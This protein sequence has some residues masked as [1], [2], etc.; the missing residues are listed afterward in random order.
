M[1]SRKQKGLIV[2]FLFLSLNFVQPSAAASY[3]TEAIVAGFAGGIGIVGAMITALISSNKDGKSTSSSS[4]SPTPEGT[5][6]VTGIVIDKPNIPMQLVLTNKSTEYPVTVVGIALDGNIQGVA[7]GTIPDNC[8]PIP[9]GGAATCSI[10]LTASEAAYG[11]GQATI[12]YAGGEK[13]ATAAVSVAPT[14][15]ELY[16]GPAPTAPLP[17]S[18][19]VIT[20]IILQDVTDPVTT[21][22]YYYKNAG[23]F[24]WQSPGVLWHDTF[25]STQTPPVPT[26]YVELTDSSS[27]TQCS[28][29]L[30]VNVG[31]TCAFGLKYKEKNPGDWGTIKPA[32]TN[33][34]APLLTNVLAGGALSVAPNNDISDY[35]LGYR[36]IKL[37][38]TYA[39]PIT[40]SYIKA[41]DGPPAYHPGGSVPAIVKS[42]LT[43]S[44]PTYGGY[45]H[46]KYCDPDAT[47]CDGYITTCLEPGPVSKQLAAGRTCLVWFKALSSKSGVA[48]PLKTFPITEG[49]I[50]VEA[51]G[52]KPNGEDLDTYER[53]SVFNAT[54]SNNLYAGGDFV[55]L[56]S[57]PGILIRI[58][59]W[60]GNNWSPLWSSPTA[61]GV[62]DGAVKAMTIMKGDLYI[63]GTFTLAGG[64]PLSKIARW[65]GNAWLPLGAG[66][67][68]E[69]SPSV[70]ALATDGSN[71]Y[72]GGLFTEVNGIDYTNTP[73]VA[74]WNPTATGTWS[75]LGSGL[76]NKVNAL[77][78]WG[79]DLVAGGAFTQSSSINDAKHVAKFSNS[80]GA[81]SE[82]A[83]G[84]ANEV[85]TVAGAVN[86][87]DNYLYAVES[88]A[89][90]NYLKTGEQSW[91]IGDSIGG[92]ISAAALTATN[93]TNSNQI[94]ARVLVSN[95]IYNCSGTAGS[96]LG[97][98]A[99]SFFAGL[100]TPYSIV[101]AG[102]DLFASNP[103]GT[104]KEPA[105]ASSRSLT[106]D[107]IGRQYALQTAPAL[108]I[109]SYYD[110]NSQT[111]YATGDY[112]PNVGEPVGLVFACGVSGTESSPCT[113][114]YVAALRDQASGIAWWRSEVSNSSGEVNPN[115]IGF[116]D[117]GGREN[118]KR[119]ISFLGE[120]HDYA[121]GVAHDY[122]GGGFKDW[123]LP[124][125]NGGELAA[126]YNNLKAQGKGYFVNG[127]YWS[128]TVASDSRTV[129]FQFFLDGFQGGKD[130]LANLKVRAVRAF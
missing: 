52:K 30:S 19:K 123:Y 10:I 50:R 118:T 117:D 130:L 82:I 129:W 29:G 61:L 112:W 96:A 28:S 54:Y 42:T 56:N 18:T 87:T 46:I 58:A 57:S 104:Y 86:G 106:G 76:N 31:G 98:A 70:N 20:D 90:L 111:T 126:M 11:S 122:Q 44:D 39:K 119:I 88:N 74:K 120:T 23:P 9:K 77:T 32:G 17:A 38:N 101:W 85:L 22:N 103:A 113:S 127:N 4:E 66:I 91:T 80:S 110:P 8:K 25:D 124:S 64:A 5:L 114:G 83:G 13:T 94:D 59:K 105:T 34:G 71:L 72:A 79:T 2:A 6:E 7:K 3:S 12:T 100:Y 24:V 102:S 45:P 78:M 81:W 41:E 21:Y 37:T 128:S 75:P 63:G 49:R 109:T 48:I 65:N 69:G 73:N 97:C 107:F 121:A 40:I 84:F 16:S 92:T 27:G 116:G 60:D 43:G 1:S 99:S 35:H 93:F 108:N 36:S 47:D 26:Q 51:L 95:T 15:L 125:G 67:G 14:V 53:V 33:L 115:K 55:D 68:G 89:H 62:G